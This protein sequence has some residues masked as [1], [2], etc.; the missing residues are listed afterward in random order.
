MGSH[1]DRHANIGNG[2]I[3][4][5]VLKKFVWDRDFDD[6]P[7]ILETPYINNVFSPYKDEIALLLDK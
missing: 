3:G 5:E 1:K 4:L 2:F 7:I 6:L